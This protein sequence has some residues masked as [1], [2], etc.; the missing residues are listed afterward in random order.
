MPR[1]DVYG[2]SLTA[3]KYARDKGL[4]SFPHAGFRP[5]KLITNTFILPAGYFALSSNNST[6][7]NR[8]NYFPLPIWEAHTF[9]GASVFNAGAGDNG[10]KFRL[11]VF[12]DDGSGGGPGTLEK[13][14]GEVTLT[15]ASAIRTLTSSWVAAP[16]M[17]WGAVW[18]D[19]VSSMI[20]MA[21][22]QEDTK[23]MLLDLGAEMGYF[24]PLGNN[25]IVYGMYVDTAYGA[26][27]STAVAATATLTSAPGGTSTPLPAF[28][29]KA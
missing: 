2:D 15:A 26:A 11:M 19:S 13:D 8:C 12:R 24:T 22:W 6:T 21:P 28:W 27:P 20:S 23:C 5:P 14:F 1:G 17:Y 29:L 16:G 10:E 9:Q 18:G 7:V 4:I 25:Q 3:T